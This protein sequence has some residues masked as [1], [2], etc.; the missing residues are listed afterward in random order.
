MLD[1]EFY[2]AKKRTLF[3]IEW[4]E[5]FQY[6]FPRQTKQVNLSFSMKAEERD[7]SFNI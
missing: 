5:K 4:A 3:L 7:L 6:S 1:L 2:L